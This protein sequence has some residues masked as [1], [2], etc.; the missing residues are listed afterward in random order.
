[1]E[2][3]YKRVAVWNSRRYD[4]E[5]N[6]ELSFV[7]IKEELQEYIDAKNEVDRLDAL[8]DIVYVSLGMHWKANLSMETLQETELDALTTATELVQSCDN[9]ITDLLAV[10]E[11]GHFYNSGILIAYTVNLLLSTSALL[12]RDTLKLSQQQFIEA[13]LVVCDSNDT[14]TVKKTAS[15]VKANKEK[16]GYFIPPEHRLQ[17][18]L[19]NREVL[20]NA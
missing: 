17:L 10:L 20:Q 8:C 6:A 4:R 11:L 1:M 16:G 13:M 15:D 5:Y 9:P 3:V 7:L 14:K 12:A 18:I 19:D 2:Q